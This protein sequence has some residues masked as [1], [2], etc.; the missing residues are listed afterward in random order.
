MPPRLAVLAILLF[1]TATTAWLFYR[2]VLPQWL[3]GRDDP[4]AFS[5]NLLDE[6]GANT[7]SWR[8]KLDG[9][10]AGMGTSEVHHLK[11]RTFQLDSAM[12]FNGDQKLFKLISRIASSNHVDAE[13]RLLDMSF[14]VSVEPEKM[15]PVK[16]GIRLDPFKFGIRAKVED[17][18]LKPRLVLNGDED[19]GTELTSIPV[20]KNGIVLNPAQ[21]GGKIKDLWPGKSWRIPMFNPLTSTPDNV[22]GGDNIIATV[23]EETIEWSKKESPCFRIDFKPLSDESLASRFEASTWVRR[24]DGLV[25]QQSIK[26]KT[27]DLQ[28]IRIDEKSP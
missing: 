26:M 8:L 19:S 16:F 14:D 3:A 2:E 18:K 23:S 13:G 5:V 28:L 1:W 12:T 15:K 4:P 10:E 27:L 20:S 22:R 25:L 11:D 17:G 7:T 21:V 6:L 24:S 9:K